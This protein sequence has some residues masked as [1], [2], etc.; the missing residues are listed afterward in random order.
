LDI[1]LQTTDAFFTSLLSALSCK[2]GAIKGNIVTTTSQ[3]P[4]TAVEKGRKIGLFKPACLKAVFDSERFY[5]LSVKN[6]PI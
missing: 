2:E 5:P 3:S 4:K 6:L 1:N